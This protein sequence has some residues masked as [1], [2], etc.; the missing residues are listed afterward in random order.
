MRLIVLAEVALVGLL[1]SSGTAQQRP[2]IIRTA[3]GVP[4]IYADDLWG[5]GYGL[6]WVQLE[7]YGAR[8]VNGLVA[9]KGHDKIE[10]L[11][12]RIAE[13]ESLP[14]LARELFFELG[15]ARAELEA[16]LG[17]I[18]KALRAHHRADAMSQAAGKNG[19][20]G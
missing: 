13:D 7:D 1:T 3:N 9:A 10:P 19:R 16:R 18:E 4:H 15:G 11:L 12:A 6:A 8:V 5:A 2:E 14:V 17:R 20:P